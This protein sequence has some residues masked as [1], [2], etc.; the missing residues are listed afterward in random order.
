MTAYV[1]YGLTLAKQAGYEI[2]E[3]R[4]SL[5]RNQLQTMLDTGSE[6]RRNDTDTRAFIV[7]ALAE[8]GG[9]PE[10]HIDKLLGERNDLQ[11][12][13]RALLALALS[14]QKMDQQALEVAGEI[15]RSAQ[16]SKSSAFWQPH[17][18]RFGASPYGQTE[19]TAM[20]LKALARIK[21][22]SSLLPLAARWLVSERRNAYFWNSTRDTAFAI[23][24]LIDYVRISRELTPSYDLEVYVNGE[25]V[26]AEHVSD[27]SAKRTF[28]INRKGSAVGATNHIRL[29]KRGKGSLYF[30]S[31]V[32]YYT[33]DEHVAE[34][35]SSDLNVT[36]EYYRLKVEP[37]G[38]NLK[39]TVVP[40]TG[41]IH[42]GDVL[43]VK[44][45]ITGQPGRHVMLEDP[46]PSGAEQLEAVGNLNFTYATT[47]WSDWYSSR[48]YR[49]R[50]TV[51]FLDHFDGDITFQY[52]MRV[53]VPGQFVVAPSRAE[54]MYDPARNANTATHRFTFSDT[55]G[56]RTN[57]N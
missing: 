35:G 42:S 37:D 45:R 53:Q 27:A 12:Y 16:V 11:P 1:V 20:S 6:S 36:R 55:K 5:G 4:I 48:E 19:A 15:E 26:V 33:N 10:R 43:V 54:F 30:S 40:L 32:E 21:P 38:S 56:T 2:D 28:V 9:V 17:S 49:D 3:Q 34:R 39:W 57:L 25:T 47:G 18:S 44:L 8:T 24:G 31:A 52:A 41:E 22:K 29:V 50:R 23:F 7:Y 14:R 51:F 46:I 13:G